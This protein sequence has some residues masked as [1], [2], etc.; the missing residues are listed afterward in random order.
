M[1]LKR[2]ELTD[3]AIR[4]KAFHLMK[5]NSPDEAKNYLMEVID[6]YEN[7]SQYKYHYNQKIR[8]LANARNNIDS[9]FSKYKEISHVYENIISVNSEC[10][11]N[12]NEFKGYID[13]C[14]A[15]F[16][17]IVELSEQPNFSDFQLSD[18]ASREII[19][20][21]EDEVDNKY[22]GHKHRMLRKYSQSILVIKELESI[23][24]VPNRPEGVN[25][26]K[27]DGSP[28]NYE[29]KKVWKSLIGIVPSNDQRK[30][31]NVLVNEVLSCCNYIYR[32]SMEENPRHKEMN[33]ISIMDE[34]KNKGLFSSKKIKNFFDLNDSLM[35][36]RLDIY[37]QYEGEIKFIDRFFDLLYEAESS[38]FIND[39]SS[40]E[41]KILDFSRLKI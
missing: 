1:V 36:K 22:R 13:D 38:L 18:E 5:S 15:W 8:V 4:E 32:L 37:I 29:I 11:K 30:I 26:K 10:V 23:V 27:Y 21:I 17:K 35:E 31:F 3:G 25:F 28:F 40:E 19:N 2:S 24:S 16:G 14:I 12:N 7:E 9:I 6:T 20:I 34:A 41:S 33:F 39:L